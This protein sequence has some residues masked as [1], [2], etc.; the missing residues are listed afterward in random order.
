MSCSTF[1]F[2]CVGIFRTTSSSNSS[3]LNVV[4]SGLISQHCFVHQD[5]L[6]E[7]QL[8]MTLVA[9][10]PTSMSYLWSCLY[11]ASISFIYLFRRRY[12]AAMDRFMIGW[13]SFLMV[14]IFS[15][16]VGTSYLYRY[17]VLGHGDMYAD[18]DQNK[19]RKWYKCRC[20]CTGSI[21][22]VELT[23]IIAILSNKTF[24]VLTLKSS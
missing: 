6:L 19:T 23:Q 11:V 3:E 10:T 9:L 22:I 15:A 24:F 4:S 2:P 18:A 16:I 14:F 12:R 17:K 13:N 8:L 7:C 21:W 5:R 20:V 1:C